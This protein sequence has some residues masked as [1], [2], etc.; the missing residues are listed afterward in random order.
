MLFATAQAKAT[1]E[2][3]ARRAAEVMD[4]DT[5]DLLARCE[6]IMAATEQA[7]RDEA[8]ARRETPIMRL[9]DSEWHLQHVVFNPLDYE[10][11]WI[12]NDSGTGAFSIL[13]EDELGQWLR[14]FDGRDLCNEGVNVHITVDYVGARW[15]GRMEEVGTEATSTG[16][17]IIT[18]TFM[19]DYENVKWVECWPTPFSSAFF[20]PMKGWILLGPTDWC[21]LTTLMVNLARNEAAVPNFPDDPLDLS[22]YGGG[23][24]FMSTWQIVP[25]LQG[26]VQAMAGGA[27]WSLPII[28]MEYWHDAFKIMLEDAELS[29]Q[30]DRWLTGDDPPWPG[31]NLRNG[32]L[33]VSIVD[34]SGRYSG[35]SKGGTI[36][37]GLF[38]TV[39]AM[40]EDFLGSTSSMMSGQPMPDEYMTIGVKS[41]NRMFPYVILRPGVTPGVESA[42]F[43]VSP[44]KVCRIITGGKS[45]P[46]VNEAISAL[47]QGIID[48]VGDNINIG[49]Y[50]IGSIG[51]AIDTLLFPFYSDTILAFTDTISWQR[52]DKLGWSRYMEYFQDGAEQAYTL[53]SLMAIRTGLWVTRR[54]YT[55]QVKI[56][57]SCPWM[58]G[59]NG[60]GHYWLSDRVGTTEPGDTSGRIWV[61]RV[62]KIGLSASGDD[63]HPDWSVTIGTDDNNRDP[64]EEGLE[65]IRSLVAGLHKMGFV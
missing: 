7:E 34:K 43:A 46:G 55:H 13:A 37:D 16:D 27:L 15:G 40:A 10:F 41:T 11:E 19:H 59:D 36:F 8:R 58:L 47:I 49:G 35:T 6:A 29:V 62:K 31:A 42:R 18:A 60:V 51:G 64:F 17:N 48:V 44:E 28:R 20:Q 61:D 9:W 5:D 32:A 2:N 54:K 23:G 25:N 45:M 65:R 1:I 24:G 52:A 50:G 3:R 56:L 14:D 57:D 38:H 63:F 33:V 22:A 21:A 53:G 4:I 30:C 39:D 12:E 26:F